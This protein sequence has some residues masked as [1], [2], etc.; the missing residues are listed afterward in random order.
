M[1]SAGQDQGNIPF[2]ETNSNKIIL[3]FAYVLC[4]IMGDGRMVLKNF[5]ESSYKDRFMHK[6]RDDGKSLTWK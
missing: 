2:G 4:K 3:S 5:Y 6:S 1:S